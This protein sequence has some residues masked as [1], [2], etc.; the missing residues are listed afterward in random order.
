MGQTLNKPAYEKHEYEPLGIER[1]TST[2][3]RENHPH[4]STINPGTT[5]YGDAFH[6]PRSHRAIQQSTTRNRTLSPMEKEKMKNVQSLDFSQIDNHLLRDYTRKTTRLSHISKTFGKWVVCF[7]IGLIVGCVAYLIK[8][9]VDRTQDFKFRFSGDYISSGNYGMAFLIY[10]GVNLIF[11][12]L[13]SLLVIFAGPLS[14]SSGIPEVIGYLN[15]VRI[16]KSLSLKTLTGKVLSLILAYSSGLVV[17]PEG[18]MIHIGSAVGAAVGQLR[19]TTLGLYPGIFWRYHNDKDKRDFISTGAAAGITAAFGAPIGGVLF[20]LEEASSFWSRQLTWRTF[21][22]CMIATFTVNVLDQ[23]LVGTGPVHDSGLLTFGFSRAYLYKYFEFAFFIILGMLGGLA[24]ALFVH[25]NIRL[26][27]WRRDKFGSLKR[28]QMIVARV[29]EVALVGII[30]SVACFFLSYVFKCRPLSVIQS[31]ATVCEENNEWDMIQFFCP[32]NYYNEMASLLFTSPDA[33]MR[34]LYSRTHNM[35]TPLPL[36]VFT[37]VYFILAIISSGIWVAGGLFIPMMLVGAGMGRLLGEAVLLFNQG[38]DPS[39]YAL[40]GSAAMMG[41]YSRLTI[42]LVVIMVELTEGT[43]YLIPLIMAVMVSKWVSDG[44]THSLYDELMVQKCIPFLHTHPPHGLML[45]E[46]GD[47]MATRVVC[48]R[49]V[50]SVRY[51]L[52]VLRSDNHNGYPVVRGEIP[53]RSNSNNNN[54]NNSGGYQDSGSDSPNNSGALPGSRQYKGLILRAQLLVM[55]QYRIFHD[56]NRN[57]RPDFD[58]ERFSR[59]I[60]FFPPKL[61]FLER[62]IGPSDREMQMDL[63]PFMNMSAITIHTNFSAGEAY[64]IFRTLGLRHLTVIDSNNDVV[65]MVTRKDLL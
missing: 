48:M 39:I 17:G 33:A 5:F 28:P 64:R 3:E 22:C 37:V 23:G 61:D 45:L 31:E 62:M 50:E 19:S 13:A 30:T 15:G 6:H 7:F 42:S 56:G 63:R 60:S 53:S 25:V 34:R 51:V 10:S 1:S 20:S 54:G 32:P 35:F 36:A 52:Q 41:G 11:V 57:L 40:I 8:T 59:A 21:F 65:G 16:P 29:F 9:A 2:Y 18:P 49:E 24:G 58:F 12:L 26:N 44:V 55:L 27:A 4:H 46:V 43:Q 14:S 47:V 38:T